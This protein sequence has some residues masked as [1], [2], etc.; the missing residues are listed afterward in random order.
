[1]SR[2]PVESI[3]ATSPPVQ[4][5][6]AH[7]GRTSPG[8]CPDVGD[9]QSVTLIDL[10]AGMRIPASHRFAPPPG[11]ERLC[12]WCG[13]V[14]CWPGDTPPRVQLRGICLPCLLNM[15]L[16]YNARGHRVILIPDRM[17]AD[18]SMPIRLRVFAELQREGASAQWITP[19]VAEIADRLDRRRD[20]VYRAMRRLVRDGYAITRPVAKGHPHRVPDIRLVMGTAVSTPL[21]RHTATG[22]RR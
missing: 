1:M 7:T 9:V 6:L 18:G 11:S 2:I 17:L 4:G 15:Q 22:T 16:L 8:T 20:S 12:M 14:E 19:N 3:A 21:D 10:L 13:R 5:A